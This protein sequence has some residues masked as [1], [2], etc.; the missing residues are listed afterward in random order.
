MIEQRFVLSTKKNRRSTAVFQKQ[1]PVSYLLLVPSDALGASPTE[2]DDTPETTSDAAG[3]TAEVATTLGTTTGATGACSSLCGLQA[4]KTTPL[5]NA[6]IATVFFISTILQS[7]K[8][9]RKTRA[10]L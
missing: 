4:T 7:S 1:I 9:L 2:E 10:V 5:N 6:A 8:K 3:A